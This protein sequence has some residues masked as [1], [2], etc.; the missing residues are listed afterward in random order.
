MYLY[1]KN[2]LL[3]QNKNKIL[4]THILK[5]RDILTNNNY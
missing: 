5:Q 3:T 2:V 4:T 1:S